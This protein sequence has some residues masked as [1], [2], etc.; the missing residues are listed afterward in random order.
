MDTSQLLDYF[1]THHAEMLDLVRLLVDARDAQPR[2]AA[3]GRLCG[4]ARGAPGRRRR[5]L[6]D[7]P[8]SN[9][10]QPRAGG[11]AQES[12]QQSA[13]R[14][15]L[16]LCHYDTVWP[17]GALATHP[18]RVEEGRAYGPGIFDMQTSLALVEFG[19]RAVRDL[20]LRLPR[21]VVV[22]VTS[23]EEIGSTTS[24][25]LIEEE[26]LRAAYVLVLESPLAGGVLKTARKGT[27]TFHIAAFGRAAH[28]GVEPEK[29][30]NAIEEL[31]HQVLAVHRLARPDAGTTVS[32][33]TIAGGSVSNVIPA[34]AEAAVDVRAWTQAEAE[35]IDRALHGLTP[36]LPGARVEV[37]GGWNRPPLERSATQ[38]LFERVRTIGFSLGLD[39][40]EGST[41]GGSDGNF[42]GAL[43]VP[44]LDGLGVPGAGAHA[45]HEHILVDE[46]PGSCSPAGGDVDGVV[47]SRKLEVAK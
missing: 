14:P 16:V 6:L 20:G 37:T 38:A 34:H 23:D 8:Q 36:V 5:Q 28:A 47:R 11:V 42:T 41:G 2:Q 31:A 12:A 45:D 46:I 43:G 40:Q 39:L 15:A 3:P 22:L 44:T 29:G 35:R 10:R 32:V 13:A 19:L 30:V 26:A 27:G 21:P 24:R 9:P 25:A 4:A 7:P 18:F 33:G 1:A 17:V